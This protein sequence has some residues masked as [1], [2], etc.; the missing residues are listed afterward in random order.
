MSQHWRT[1][2]IS[3]YRARCNT[4]PSV[5]MSKWYSTPALLYLTTSSR[6][7]VGENGGGTHWLYDHDPP[8]ALAQHPHHAFDD[9]L[10]GEWDP[11]SRSIILRPVFPGRSHSATHSFLILP[12]SISSCRVCVPNAKVFCFSFSKTDRCS[13]SSPILSFYQLFLGFKDANW[14]Y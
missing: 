4:R 14:L 8:A 12:R 6:I 7:A 5:V 11:A 10:R 1:T 13:F 3:T 2:S 9:C